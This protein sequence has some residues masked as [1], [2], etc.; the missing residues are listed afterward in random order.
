METNSNRGKL[1]LYYRPSNEARAR[2]REERS[3]VM[4]EPR[5]YKGPTS[6]LMFEHPKQEHLELPGKEICIYPDPNSLP[7]L[8]RRC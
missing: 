2:A 5:Y 4:S 3:D 8:R 1:L 6:N 7:L